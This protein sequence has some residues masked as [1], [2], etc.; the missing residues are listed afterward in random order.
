MDREL[1][2]TL[3]RCVSIANLTKDEAMNRLLAEALTVLNEMCEVVQEDVQ[4][5][6]QGGATKQKSEPPKPKPSSRPKKRRCQTD[7]RMAVSA[8]LQPANSTQIAPKTASSPRPG[9][10]IEMELDLNEP[11]SPG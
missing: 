2:S 10:A 6:Q 5:G 1:A 9:P 3:Q 11:S 7:T 4:D 8:L